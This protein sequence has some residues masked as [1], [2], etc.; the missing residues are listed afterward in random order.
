M[1]KTVEPFIMHWTVTHRHTGK[2]TTYR[3]CMGAKRAQDRMDG[4]WG[5]YIAT[6]RAV[7]SDQ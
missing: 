3:S 2:V 4:L 5:A 7:W 6:V 1:A